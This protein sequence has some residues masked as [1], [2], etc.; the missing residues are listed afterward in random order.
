MRTGLISLILVLLACSVAH[1][2]EETGSLFGW[3]N[4][5]FDRIGP[6]HPSIA[7]GA[8][9]GA[10]RASM[11][12]WNDEL[13]AEGSTERFGL[14]PATGVGLES[15]FGKHFF[16][17]LD[18]GYWVQTVSAEATA[19]EAEVGTVSGKDKIDLR[20]MPVT[21]AGV[22]YPGGLRRWS[23][24]PYVGA[25]GG[26][27]PV[28]LERTRTAEDGRSIPQDGS[29][30]DLLGYV[31]AGVSRRLSYTLTL[32][33]EGRYVFG[34]YVQQKLASGVVEDRDVSLSGPQFEMRVYYRVW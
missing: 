7:V 29:G 26:V 13:D 24:S 25:G 33:A 14:G 12:F 10:Y 9:L 17:R 5:L 22:V 8:E 23:L 31:L 2:Q 15:G 19:M 3:L 4:A 18:V 30:G 34:G 1:A 16:I 27:C 28:R 32:S 11:D 21:L 6:R 20:L